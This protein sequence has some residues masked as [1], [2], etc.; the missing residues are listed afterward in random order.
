MPLPRR[1]SGRPA[2]AA[3]ATCARAVARRRATPSTRPAPGRRRLR[4]LRLDARLPRGPAPRHP[5]RRPRAERPPRSGQPA[6]RAVRA[7][8]RRHVP[9]HRRCPRATVTGMPLRREIAPLDRGGAP[10]R[11]RWRTSASTRQ[12]ADASSS[13]AAR[14]APSASTTPS[15]APRP[16]CAPRASRCCTSPVPARSSCRVDGVPG[17]PY[18]VVPYCRP[19]GARLRRRRPRRR[20]L[21]R[22]HRV[23]ADR[24]RACPPSTCRCPS[25]TASSG[26]TP[27]PSSPPAA[28]CSSRTP[29][30]RPRWVERTARAPAAS[31][32]PG[33]PR[34]R[35][36]PRRWAERERRRAA[37][38]PRRSTRAGEG[39][40]P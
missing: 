19:D 13:P 39:A 20:P 29:T 15:P 34:W 10:R 25:A 14:S 7:V 9:R 5:H 36:P 16:R 3:R 18:V 40:R 31:T 23:R 11:G 35:R 27:P 30:S 4:R 8:R 1:P 17:A 28:G 12:L 21:R 24:R 38:R 37:R 26:S 22:Q 32:R 6:R 2:A 33:S